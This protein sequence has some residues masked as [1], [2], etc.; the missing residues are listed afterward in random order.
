MNPVARLGVFLRLQ[1][2]DGSS[3]SHFF[4]EF[5]QPVVYPWLEALKN[6]A[7]GTFYLAVCPRVSY[8][9]LD[10]MDVVVIA[11]RQEFMVGELRPVVGDDGI[12][13]PE[14]VDDIGEE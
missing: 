2:T 13:N 9:Q 7:V 1:M 3:T 12:W 4:A 8:G 10:H 14:P 6:H 11:E 5:F